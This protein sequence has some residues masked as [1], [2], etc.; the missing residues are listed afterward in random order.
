MLIVKVSMPSSKISQLD[1]LLT[2]NGLEQTVITANGVNRRVTLNSIKSLVNKNDVGLPVVDNTSDVNKP[3]SI[4]TAAV[5]TTKADVNHIHG[6]NEIT[7][8]RTEIETIVNPLITNSHIS[9]VVVG[10]LQW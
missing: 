1:L 3:V 9:S 8:I 5:L 6:F 4:A 7:N 2:P 10:E